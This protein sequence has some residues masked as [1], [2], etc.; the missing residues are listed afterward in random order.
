[1]IHEFISDKYPKGG[2]DFFLLDRKAAR[3][4]LQSEERNG[5][6]Q[7]LM[8]W[9]G[10]SNKGLPYERKKR[11]IGKSGWTL[12]KKIKQFI[13]IFVGNSY[14]PLRAMSVIGA[15]SAFCGFGYAVYIFISAI[16]TR[17]LGKTE[18]VLGWSSIITI[19]I[20]FSGL[21]LL[22]LGIIGEYLWRIFDYVKNRP[23]YVVKEII[24]ETIDTIYKETV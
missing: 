21:I 12:S 2:F 9:Y 20:F 10:F 6:N 13:D 17:M 1:M 7:I 5:V 19:I 23:R 24:D 11:E 22:S 14:L 8:L 16:V 3:Q 18:S 15:V 4:Y